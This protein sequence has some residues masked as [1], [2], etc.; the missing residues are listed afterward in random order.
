MIL[1]STYLLP[2]KVNKF[3][4][5]LSTLEQAI[6]VFS[7]CAIQKVVNPAVIEQIR[8]IAKLVI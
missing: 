8:L 6:Q 3:S 7:K 5:L 4:E 2:I 1:F